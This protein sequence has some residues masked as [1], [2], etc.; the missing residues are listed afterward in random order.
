MMTATRL[1]I[2][3]AV[4]GLIAVLIALLDSRV[5]AENR[6]TGFVRLP[7]IFGEGMVLQAGWGKVLN[8]EEEIRNADD[9]ELR[10]FQVKH[11]LRL[12][13][14]RDVPSDGW[15]GITP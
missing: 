9:T 1:L 6:S 13:P 5:H 11:A 15:P 7:R 14:L 4:P 2:R 8:D 12:T 10:L 3:S